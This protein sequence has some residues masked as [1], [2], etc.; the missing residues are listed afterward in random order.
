MFNHERISYRRDLT[1]FGP[2]EEKSA[3]LAAL[4][5]GRSAVVELSGTLYLLTPDD[6]GPLDAFGGVSIGEGLRISGTGFA[7]SAMFRESEMALPVSELASRW[8]GADASGGRR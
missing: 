8:S 6:A 4:Q 5:S 7:V 2:E 3:L 1:R